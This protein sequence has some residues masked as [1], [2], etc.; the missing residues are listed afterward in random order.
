MRRFIGLVV[1]ASL[2]VGCDSGPDGPGDLSGSVLSPD[3]ALG[4]VVFEVVGA[5][6]EGFS[7]AGGTRVFWARQ[8]DPIVYR[9]I[10]IGESG[11]ELKFSV[12]V[13][14][15]GGRLPRATVVSAVDLNNHPFLPVTKEYEVKFRR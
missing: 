15:R 4:G 10:E 14:D 3:P 5:G 12:S 8:E 7:G 11:G 9:V 2:A 1:L 13:Q 6:I